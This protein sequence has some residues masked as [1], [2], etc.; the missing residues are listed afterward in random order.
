[1]NVF[2]LVAAPALLLASLAAGA[3]PSAAAAPR[4]DG[5]AA[6]AKL[7]AGRTAGTPVDCIAVTS[8]T[9]TEIVD[10]QALV[11]RVGG[12]LYVNVP[13]SGAD[14]LDD[15]TILVTRLTG[16]Q[17]CRSDRIDLVDRVTRAPRG[18]ALLDRFVPYTKAKPPRAG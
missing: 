1:M 3:L 6:L 7:L 4:S 8:T 11:Y 10:R 12:R 16:S 17:L 13:R 18:F 9:S 15:D 14:R 2:A 5:K